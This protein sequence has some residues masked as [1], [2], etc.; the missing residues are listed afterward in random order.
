M[1]RTRVV[2]AVREAVRYAGYEP[3]LEFH[4]EMPVGPMNR[5]AD[6]T[7][8]RKLLGWEPRV[9]FM[10]GLRQTADWYFSTKDRDQVRETL[11]SILTERTLA[12]AVATS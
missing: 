8:A 9:K 6:N 3:R 1:E 5:V 7:L 12:P 4:P 11:D 2:D 10:D